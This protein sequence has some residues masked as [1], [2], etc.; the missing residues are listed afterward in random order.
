[1]LQI[2][3]WGIAIMLVVKAFDLFHQE[4]IAKAA[5]A[6]ASPFLPGIGGLIAI[7]GAVFLVLSANGQAEQMPSAPTFGAR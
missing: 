7:F 2:A 5:G 3:I 6:P 1:M 4:A